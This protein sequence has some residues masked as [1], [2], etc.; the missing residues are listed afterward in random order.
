[1]KKFIIW[2]VLLSVVGLVLPSSNSSGTSYRTD[3]YDIVIYGGG[4][5]AVAA[6]LKASDVTK[7]QKRILLIVPERELGSL[8]T[9][10]AQN[11]FDWNEYRSSLLPP[12]LPT[13]YKGAQ[14]GS[15]Y[16]FLKEMS[17]S[18]PPDTMAGYLKKLLSVHRNI[19]VLYETDI[20][21]VESKPANG[22]TE[23]ADG[24][25]ENPVG[26]A[27]SVSGAV[28]IGRTDLRNGTDLSNGIDLR[29]GTDLSNR[30][31]LRNGVEGEAAVVTG[32]TLQH[33]IKDEHHRYIFDPSR[34]IRVLAP[35]YVDASET[36]RL[37]RLSGHFRGIIGRADQ[38]SDQAQMAATLMFKLKGIQAQSVPLSHRL[39]FHMHVSKKGSLQIWGGYEI[40]RSALFH[41]YAMQ[42]DY[43]R[44]KPYN[45]G[46]DGYESQG[47]LTADT[48]F[49]MN[50]LLIYQVDA[51]KAW[52]DKVANNGFYP[53]D[54]ELDPEIAREMAM[55]ELMKP[56]FLQMIR[57]LPGF[58]HARL[59][60]KDGRPVA[61]EMLYL[62]E[63]IHSSNSNGEFALDD[64]GVKGHDQ[65]YY[66][67]RIGLGYYLF[68]SNTYTKTESLTA[69]WPASPWYVPY[70]T[71]VSPELSNVLIPGYAANI[72]S[73]AWT[74]M[75][76][77]P[78]L[79]VLGDAAGVAA[80]LA[81]KGEFAVLQPTEGQMVRLQEQLR[82]VQAIL[83]K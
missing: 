48:E 49:W 38:H 9:A 70:E 24:E 83:E 30:A 34:S 45:A 79:I 2:G 23:T 52:R 14:A 62:R 55:R 19:T 3:F 5:Q 11:L 50:M 57:A 58:E 63:S 80:G 37:V 71:L 27:D 31:V 29:N 4:P 73:F 7:D 81:A 35:T 8:W 75:R 61:G 51:R 44:M 40:N 78:N 28:R 68:D 59:V 47:N 41:N 21:G 77:Y 13:D 15:A 54:G 6:A 60:M 22:D 17:L 16:L 65:R 12:G 25:R 46:E 82:K 1:M 64:A 69:K 56:A 42:S 74:A 66:A 32:L 20:A 67:H 33:L 26:I 10:G 36:G 76:V 53:T 43:F 18:F 39:P 72:S